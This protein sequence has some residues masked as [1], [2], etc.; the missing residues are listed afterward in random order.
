[1]PKKQRDEGLVGDLKA[2]IAI[3]LIVDETEVTSTSS[4]QEDLGADSIDAVELVMMLEETYKIT[5]DDA[6]GERLKTFQN[7]VDLVTKLLNEKQKGGS[8]SEDEV[9]SDPV[10]ER[11]DEPSAEPSTDPTE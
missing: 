8:V 3:L 1:M 11:D 4:L 7:V 9:P 6:Q 2:L 5:I 10:I